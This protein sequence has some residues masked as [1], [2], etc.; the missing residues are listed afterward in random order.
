MPK[1]NTI[2][3]FGGVAQYLRFLASNPQ[4]PKPK[5]PRPKRP[6]SHRPKF[7]TS[8]VLFGVAQYLRFLASIPLRGVIP[9]DFDYVDGFD[10]TAVTVEPLGA[11]HRPE[12]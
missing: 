10:V 3:N 7:N 9:E 4:R 12:P 6:K 5:R 8:Y 11:S 1:H 2:I